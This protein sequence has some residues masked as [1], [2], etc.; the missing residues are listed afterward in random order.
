MALHMQGYML[1]CMRPDRRMKQLTGALP[2]STTESCCSPPYL[3]HLSMEHDAGTCILFGDG[4]GAVLLSAAAE[5]TE[6]GMLAFDM[7]SDGSGACHLN[8]PID[9]C[10]A[11]KADGDSEARSAPTAYDNI[12]MDGQEVFKFAVRAV[13]STLKAALARA[14]MTGEDVDW[15]VMHQANQRILDSAAK[16]LRIAPEKVRHPFTCQA[17]ALCKVPRE[18]WLCT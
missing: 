7:H 1:S 13:P 5:G 8:A 15:L 4:A 12:Y 9:K 17:E 10:S 3:S 6:D 2:A 11:G 14:S 18:S 16:K